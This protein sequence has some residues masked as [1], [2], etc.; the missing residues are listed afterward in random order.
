MR[1]RLRPLLEQLY[2]DAVVAV[3]SDRIEERVAAVPNRSSRP[4]IWRPEDILLIAYGDSIRR[5]GEAPLRSLGHFLKEHV[6]GL[7]SHIH[8]LPFFSLYIG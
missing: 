8:L 7:I 5:E 4:E 3:L 2:D 6:P 1:L